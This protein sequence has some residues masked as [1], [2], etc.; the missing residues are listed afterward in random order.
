MSRARTV[1]PRARPPPPTGA[2]LTAL[3]DLLGHRWALRILWELQAR[4]LS[5]RMLAAH[6]GGVSPTVLQRRL[7]ELRDAKVVELPGKSGYAL[8]IH[9]ALL[10]DGL[11]PLEQWALR[12]MPLKRASRRGSRPAPAPLGR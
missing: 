4:P 9:G 11:L 12:W 7:R 10:V 1:R 8:S 5:S 3:L 6:C 2:R